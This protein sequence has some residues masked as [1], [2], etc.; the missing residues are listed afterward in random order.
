MSVKQEPNEDMIENTWESGNTW[1]K[2]RDLIIQWV[3]GISI[4][5]LCKRTA[6]RT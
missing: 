3:Q 5:S 4:I 6:D 1:D 2:D